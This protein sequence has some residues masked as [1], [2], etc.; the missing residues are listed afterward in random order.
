MFTRVPERHMVSQ[1]VFTTLYLMVLSLAQ[2]AVI[3]FHRHN[4]LALK[5]SIRTM[6]LRKG[7]MNKSIQEKQVKPVS[8]EGGKKNKIFFKK[9]KT[10][11]FL[12]DFYVLLPDFDQ[13]LKWSKTPQ[14]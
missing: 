12:F 1:S 3:Q 14:I 11:F 7:S 6:P 2:A 9:N 8:P 4:L 10:F 13:A 5:S